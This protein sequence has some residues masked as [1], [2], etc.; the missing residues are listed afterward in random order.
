MQ[1]AHLEKSVKSSNNTNNTEQ[2]ALNTNQKIQNL[3][4]TSAI[5]AMANIDLKNTINTTNDESKQ[6]V[7]TSAAVTSSTGST[8]KPIEMNTFVQLEIDNNNHACIPRV[9]RFCISK[10]T[11]Q[12]DFQSIVLAVKLDA[13]KRSLRTVDIPLV[14]DA[15][16]ETFYA[17]LNLHYTVTYPH[18]LKKDSNYLYFY[19]QKR[20]KLKNRTILGFK[21]LAIGFI[22]LSSILQKPFSSELPL[23]LTSSQTSTNNNSIILPNNSQIVGSLKI[24]SLTS[25]PVESLDLD[26]TFTHVYKNTQM[27]KVESEDDE[28]ELNKIISL[29]KNGSF[30]IDTGKDDTR[31]VH[32]SDNENEAKKKEG[33]TKN[34]TGK[35]L[36]FIK[37]FRNEN[38]TNLEEEI[39]N[40][41]NIDDFD[42]DNIEQISDYTES[43]AEPDAY[44]IV[45]E[46]KPKLQPFFSNNP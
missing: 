5:N 2:K 30:Q 35:I 7:P 37:R 40:D 10:L 19:I 32:E 1:N 29:H 12:N 6:A 20:K 28:D 26:G 14:K 36:S 43:D 3:N 16:R 24:Q 17:D 27:D 4:L 21:T 45:S 23:Y 31:L 34:F 11:V 33:N 41:T 39:V 22:D 15:S 25:L 9:C 46:L 13:S 38:S 42:L 8:N 44:S 18:F